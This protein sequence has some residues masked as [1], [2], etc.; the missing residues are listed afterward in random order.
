MKHRV[1]LK[2][3]KLQFIFGFY[4]LFSNYSYA[5]STYFTDYDGITH[6][7]P[8]LQGALTGAFLLKEAGV[9]TAPAVLIPALAILA[10]QFSKQEF[11]DPIFNFNHL[12]V[13]GAGILTGSLL[14]LVWPD[15]EG[16]SSPWLSFEPEGGL[17]Y[18]TSLNNRESSPPN[19]F[20]INEQTTFWIKRRLG[21]HLFSGGFNVGGLE[22]G[23]NNFM[24]GGGV[25]LPIEPAF[26]EEQT[27][28][29]SWSAWCG[30]DYG[31]LLFSFAE[32]GISFVP[33]S[34]VFFYSLGMRWRPSQSALHLG[35]Q[36]SMIPYSSSLILQSGLQL[37]F[38][39]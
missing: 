26:W 10:V 8:P 4:L 37:G 27:G 38:T 28:R 33:S 16:D 21:L 15:N 20:M 22:S 12:A 39:F 5:E 14:F 2:L 7:F 32:T 18:F 31:L 24:F 29:E 19:S 34:S 3:K 30:I 36:V 11:Y 35:A 17:L 25:R 9:S 1:K 23:V 6:F 13:T